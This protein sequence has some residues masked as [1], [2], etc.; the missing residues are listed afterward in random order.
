MSNSWGPPPRRRTPSIASVTMLS[1]S[2]L[3]LVAGIVLPLAVP[4]SSTSR[5]QGGFALS[6]F[7]PHLLDG[8]VNASLLYVGMFVT[9]LA[10]TLLILL[11]L[12]RL[13][14]QVLWIIAI[15]ASLGLM[16]ASS[17]I[18]L[19]LV[20]T[21]EATTGLGAMALPLGA[22]LTELCCVIP[23]VKNAWVRPSAF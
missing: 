13:V 20:I 19:G 23:G 11:G 17:L 22:L 3:L 4:P 7:R 6:Q 1:I 9:A 14:G 18:L 16:L 21:E 5:W 10:L 12:A 15:I 2:A 8:S